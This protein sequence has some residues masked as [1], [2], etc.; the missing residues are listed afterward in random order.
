MSLI[1]A[2]LCGD[3]GFK[4]RECGVWVSRLKEEVLLQQDAL[5][6]VV[7]SCELEDEPFHG[8]KAVALS[9]KSM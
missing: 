6:L 4:S 9:T 1:A 7:A 2:P 5:M 8:D 3:P